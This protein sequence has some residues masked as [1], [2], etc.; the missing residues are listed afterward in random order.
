MVVQIEKANQFRIA[1]KKNLILLTLIMGVFF[2]CSP[3]RVVVEK[4]KYE[5]F[6]LSNYSSFDFAQIETPNDSLVPYQEIV[7]QLKQNFTA[8]MEARG[9]KRDATDPDLRINFGVVV[10][11]KVQT[12]ETNLTTDPFTYAGQRN[13]YWEVREIP[14]NTYR[15]GSLSVHFINNP[16]NVLVWAGTI[17]EVVPKKEEKKNESIENAINQ[18]FKYLDINNK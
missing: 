5:D 12:R 11:D 2:S 8:A 6:K 17:S 7:D 3:T 1:V 14:V 9:L 10:Q 13:Y 18:I 4:N 16:G 15:E